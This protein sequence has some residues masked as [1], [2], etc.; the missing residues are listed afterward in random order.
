MREVAREL[1]VSE[2]SLSRWSR[3]KEEPTMA[4]RAIE[5]VTEPARRTSAMV[6]RGPRGLCIE[7]LTVAELAELIARL[8]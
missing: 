1:G 8:S 7:G 5:V 3:R 4:F 2:T 6:V